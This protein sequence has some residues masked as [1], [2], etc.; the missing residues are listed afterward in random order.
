MV[1]NTNNNLEEKLNDFI[2][3]SITII[4]GGFLKSE[5]SILCSD[6]HTSLHKENVKRR[7]RK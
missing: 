4:Q 2:G 1:Q 3:K 5:Y 6:C 7:H